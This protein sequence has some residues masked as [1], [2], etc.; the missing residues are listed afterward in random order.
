M[1]ESRTKYV[2]Y[3]NS[4]DEINR[5]AEAD[6]AAFISGAESSYRKN[7]RKIAEQIA[8]E[9]PMCRLVMLAG[10]SSSGKTT[11][12][13]RL[14]SALKEIGV[15]CVSISLDDFYLGE[16]RAPLRPD[17]RRDYECLQALDVKKI[18]ECLSGLVEN[19]RCEMPVFDFEQHVP[20][21]RCRQVVLHE[22]EVA[23][24]EGIHALNPVLIGHLPALRV[25]RIYISV[26]QGVTAA[27]R[28]LLGPNDIR[29]V[30]RLVR[31]YNFR[32]TSPENTLN[33]WENVMEGEYRYIKPFRKDADITVNSFHAYEVCALKDRALELLHTVPEGSPAR[34]PAMKL[35]A[36][37]ERFSPVD[38]GLIPKD[39]VIREFIGGGVA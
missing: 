7:I 27:G 13:H 37:L 39:S 8:G 20:Y 18:Q 16:N 32:R 3:R 1:L 33:M 19:N 34:A 22:N 25:R 15:G 24:V 29:L 35:Q 11:T 30:R 31:D 2:T 5:A 21:P 38:A 12:A 9:K 36:A 26:K 4:L 14:I 17:G 23:V 6:P 10:P 28:E